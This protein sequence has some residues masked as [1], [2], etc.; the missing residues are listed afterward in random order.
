M[1]NIFASFVRILP[2]SAQLVGILCLF[3]TSGC[4]T[5]PPS[6]YKHYAFPKN[7]AFYGNTQRPYRTLGSV[8]SKVDY[9]SLDDNHEEKDLC[10]NY[11]NK[12]VRDL[13]SM[14]KKKGGDAVIDVKSVVYLEDGKQESYPRAECSDDGMEGQSLTQGIAVKWKPLKT[15]TLSAAQKSLQ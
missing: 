12:S 10:T 15:E 5:L 8:R 1:K 2:M 11:F 4:S 9:D 7:E 3:T 14:A 13:V 6:K